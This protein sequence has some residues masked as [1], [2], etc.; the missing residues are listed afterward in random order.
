MENPTN[1]LMLYFGAVGAA[2]ILV[3]GQVFEPLREVLRF[4]SA[5]RFR[6]LFKPGHDIIH[7][8]QC[9]GF[10]VG[11]LFILVHTLLQTPCHTPPLRLA[12]SL[13]VFACGV[14]FLTLTADLVLSALYRSDTQ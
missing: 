1:L 9:C 3:R 11:L 14:S 12:F 5:E 8:P 4:A 13:F 6:L 7:C 2:L 10:W